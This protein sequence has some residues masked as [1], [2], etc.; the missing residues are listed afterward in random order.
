MSLAAVFSPTPGM[1]GRLSRRIAAE[2]GVLHVLGGVDAG[3]L[4]DARLVVV[5]VVRHAALV[6]DD[7]DVRVLDEL[8]AVPVAGDDQDV[9]AAGRG[10]RGEGG[11]DVVG[12]DARPAR[13]R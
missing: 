9:V 5:G 12:L 10:Q 2:R 7:P 13:W 6:V 4:D 1:P 3:A 11:D 8:V